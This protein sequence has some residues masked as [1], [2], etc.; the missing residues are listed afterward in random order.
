[1]TGPCCQS[2]RVAGKG[3]WIRIILLPDLFRQV[4]RFV[5]ALPDSE[6]GQSEAAPH[7]DI[8]AKV[9]GGC[10]AADPGVPLTF[11]L[12]REY[13][14]DGDAKSLPLKRRVLPH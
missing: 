1:M 5:F 9:E 10:D 13:A 2:I 14:V 4:D 3:L 6:R 12:E 8:E 7:T 11:R